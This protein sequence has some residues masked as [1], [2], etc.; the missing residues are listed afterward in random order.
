MPLCGRPGMAFW[1]QRP[2]KGGN[3]SIKS[4]NKIMGR[5]L[6]N[7]NGTRP[8]VSVPLKQTAILPV[9]SNASVFDLLE[10]A[11]YTKLKFWEQIL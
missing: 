8:V 9:I 7:R 4:K 11:C 5:F 6:M 3:P 2:F 1:I 10:I